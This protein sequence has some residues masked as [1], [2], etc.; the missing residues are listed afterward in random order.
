M[1]ER[2]L[3]SR[4]KSNK[5]ALQNTYMQLRKIANHPYV[6]PEVEED[7]MTSDQ[8]DENLIRTSGKFELLDRILP[9]LIATNHKVRTGTCLMSRI[10]LL[11]P[12]PAAPG[13]G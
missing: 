6:F 5:T 9:K 10:L 1:K 11:H 8:V 12:S 13:T 7:F 2:L 3:T 4:K